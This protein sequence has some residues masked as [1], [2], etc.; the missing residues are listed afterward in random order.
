MLSV[1][2]STSNST[3]S[4]SL[5]SISSSVIFHVNQDNPKYTL[6]DIST[7]TLYFIIHNP[8]VMVHTQSIVVF[9]HP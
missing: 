2:G 8:E 5:I 6:N 7:Y 1:F 3:T 4:I 9:G